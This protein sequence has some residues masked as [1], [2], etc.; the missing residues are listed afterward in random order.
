MTLCVVIRF[1]QDRNWQHCEHADRSGYVIA[2][3][4]V[5]TTNQLIQLH[6]VIFWCKRSCKNIFDCL[7]QSCFQRDFD[8]NQQNY[9]TNLCYRRTHIWT[10]NASKVRLSLS[11]SFPS[12]LTSLKEIRNL[13]NTSAI[14]NA[15]VLFFMIGKLM[16]VMWYKNVWF[17]NRVARCVL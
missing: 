6:H 7:V 3:K 17:Q 1:R 4:D 14:K 9:H 16:Y 8:D 12:S 15:V 11:T 10:W 13:L 5:Q 2:E